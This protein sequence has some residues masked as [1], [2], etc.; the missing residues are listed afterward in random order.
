MLPPGQPLGALFCANGLV[1]PSPGHS[2][3]CDLDVPT[4]DYACDRCGPFDAMRPIAQRDEPAPCPACTQPA[5]R[6]LGGVPYY[7]TRNGG[8]PRST[9]ESSTQGSYPR[10]RHAAGCGCC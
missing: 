10:M 6:V 1:R 2:A 3:C 4:Y 5:A 8:M 7:A 9:R